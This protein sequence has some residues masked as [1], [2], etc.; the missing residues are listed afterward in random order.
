M[1]AN[2]LER[3]LTEIDHV[4]LTRLLL[5]AK[6]D[7]AQ[8]AS[9]APLD[10][11]LSVCELVPSISVPSDVVTMYSQV[12]LSDPAER[13]PYKLTLCYPDDA[14]PAQGFVSV[15]S[16]IGTSVL[17]L[18]VGDVAQWRCP[19]GSARTATLKAMIFQPEASGDYTI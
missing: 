16:P 5:R 12:L 7:E 15:L 19:R 10:Q 1:E 17:G 3:T 6:A 4:R 14:E 13:V 18:R 8:G 9:L 2:P 11:L